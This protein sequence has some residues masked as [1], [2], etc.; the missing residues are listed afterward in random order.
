MLSEFRVKGYKN[1]EEEL[2]FDMS[3]VKSYEFSS[4]AVKDGI[5]N[6]GLIYGINGSGK[7]NL[8]HAIFDI[9][10]HLVDKEKGLKF[11]QQ[12]QN[13]IKKEPVEFSYKFA[14]GSDT[15]EYQYVKTGVQQ[16]L[17]EAVRINGKT[18]IAYSFNEKNKPFIDLK[19]A[20]TL[21]FEPNDGEDA[22]Y[23]ISIVKYIVN[24]TI[25]TENNENDVLLKFVDFVGKMLL[26]SSLETNHYMGFSN[27]SE[28]VAAGI[29]KAGRVSQFQEFLHKAGISYDLFARNIDGEDKL[30]CKFGNDSVDFFSIASKGTCSL[31]LFYY[32]LIKLGKVSLVI[33]DEFDAFYH[34]NLARVVVEELL[35]LDDTQS[36]LTTHNTDI[37]TNDLL[38]PDCYFLLSDGAIKSF[39]NLTNKD[40]RKAHNLQKMYKAG[41]FNGI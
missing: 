40:L 8:A 35:K 24:N 39:S 5:V 11:Y 21:N 12:Y 1:F 3:D 25:F 19:G 14:F 18:V 16:L 17:S 37:M 22:F 32:W 26:F 2:F 31:A 13:L 38:R 36:L 29:I 4:P 15:I 10:L 27:G 20:E 41:S 7:T 28:F 33:I 23:N 6:T 9:T 34:S 30:Y